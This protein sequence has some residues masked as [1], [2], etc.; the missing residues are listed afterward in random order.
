M[1]DIACPE[2]GEQELLT[3]I[4]RDDAIAVECGACGA[5]W[6]RD[7][8]MKCGLCGSERVAYAPKPLWERGRGEQRTPAGRIDSY[9]CSDCGGYDVTSAN[10]RSRQ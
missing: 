2:C 3:G 8:T 9:S 10:P 1:R 4:R 7:T 6:T 5:A